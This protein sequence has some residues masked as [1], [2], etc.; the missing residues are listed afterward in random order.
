MARII[1]IALAPMSPYFRRVVHLF[2]ASNPDLQDIVTESIGEGEHRQ[3]VLKLKEG[4]LEE[5]EELSPV[6]AGEEKGTE[7]GGFENLDV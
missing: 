6:I 3:I 7:D 4:G 5:G 2:I 1:N